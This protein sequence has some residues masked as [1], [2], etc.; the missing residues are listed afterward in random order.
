MSGIKLN[1][2]QQLIENGQ[3]A[4]E[5]LDN[6]IFQEKITANIK[7]F[8]KTVLELEPH[9]SAAFPIIQSARKYLTAFLSDIEAVAAAGQ[10]A[11]A[12]V[13]KERGL[14]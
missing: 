5:V 3:L 9:D 14:V 8:T 12:G 1:E 11:E 7:L 2:Q 13:E 10:D 6:P 4:K